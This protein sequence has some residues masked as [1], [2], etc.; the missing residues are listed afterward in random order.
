MS[1]AAFLGGTVGGIIMGDVLGA[2]VPRPRDNTVVAS[3]SA[4]S[5]PDSSER[6]THKNA[7]GGAVA[8][9]KQTLWLSAFIVVLAIAILGFGSRSL[10]NLRIA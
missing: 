8:D 4:A 1:A 10:N 5:V 9:A 2:A 3:T 7:E 6:A